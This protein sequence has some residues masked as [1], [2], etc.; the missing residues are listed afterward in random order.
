MNFLLAKPSKKFRS[1]NVKP[2]WSKCA[3][4]RWIVW[5]TK[6]ISCMSEVIEKFKFL[7]L[8]V[9]C[10]FD[11][12]FSQ[13]S[14]RGHL[15]LYIRQMIDIAW[16]PATTAF[17][18]SKTQ[19]SIPNVKGIMKIIVEF[20][21]FVAVE[22]NFKIVSFHTLF[23]LVFFFFSIQHRKGNKFSFIS[24]RF[25]TID[26]FHTWGALSSFNFPRALVLK[27]AVNISQEF[28]IFIHN[29]PSGSNEKN[30][31]KFYN[32]LNKKKKFLCYFILCA[33]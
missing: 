7:T 29:F 16:L 27:H 4:M 3:I 23:C 6:R 11:L 20:K 21:T 22:C 1:S 19:N 5:L 24:F 28:T 18:N 30:V 8:E 2:D 10:K 17:K 25:G 15:L 26:N 31:K 14:N 32:L 9:D 12:R 33:K 13:H